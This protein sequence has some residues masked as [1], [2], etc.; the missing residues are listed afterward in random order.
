MTDAL[1]SLDMSTGLRKVADRAKREP[2]ARFHSLAHLIDEEL[3]AGAFARLRSDAAVG[4][5]GITKEQYGQDLQSK[6]REPARAAEDEAISSSADP[7]GAHSQGEAGSELG[8]SASRPP[9]IRWSR[10]QLREVLE[11]VYEQDFLDCSY[12]FRPGRSAHDAVRALTRAVNVGEAN[13]ILEFDI[14]SFF[15][16]VRPNAAVGDAPGAGGRWVAA[17][18]SSANACMWGCWTG[19]C[20][21][22]PS[23]GT[24]QGSTLSPLLGNV[25]LHTVLDRWFAEEVRPRLRG[26]A[27]FIRFADD[28]VFGFERQDDARRVLAV[29][30]KRMERFGLTLHPE[31]TR[32]LDF[33]RP[34]RSRGEG[35]SPTTFD[36]LGFCWYWRRTRAGSWAVACKTRR[37]R[38]ARAIQ[39]SVCLVS[40]E[41][42]TPPVS[43]QHAALRRRVQGHINYFGVNGNIQSLKRF[44]HQVQ[45]SWF[46]WLNRRSQRARL[47]WERFEDLLKALPL[48]ECANCRTHLEMSDDQA[49]R[50]TH[51]RKSRTAEIPTSGSGEGPGRATSLGYSTARPSMPSTM[52]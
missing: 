40:S 50:K 19:R 36:F 38:L 46:K 10:M 23:E 35:R 31:K 2:A 30:S 3:L 26:K 52:R 47:D 20:S 12:G 29:L 24:V 28:G 32:L 42:S 9:K 13:W 5:D 21:T 14:A 39:A 22:E 16:S 18:D 1:T 44:V 4:V 48:P 25:Y 41:Q 45:R 27:T 33:R 15:D 11:A 7:T 43:Q 37:A 34:S 6:L 17:C 49:T 8:R 51:P